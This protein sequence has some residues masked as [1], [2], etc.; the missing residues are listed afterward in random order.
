MVVIKTKQE[1]EIMREGGKVLAKIMKRLARE[2]RPGISTK[3]LEEMTEKLI[4]KINRKAHGLVVQPSFKG[5]RNF[6]ASL[7]VSINKE[8]VHGIPSESRILKNGDIVSLDLGLKYKRYYT[9]MAVTIPVGKISSEAKKLIKIT[10]KA[11][12]IGLKEIKPNKRIG[13][14]SSVIQRY[15]ESQGFSVNQKLTGHGIG[16]KVHEPPLIPNYAQG[17][18][19]NVKLVAGMTFCLE[20]MVNVGSSEVMCLFD[21][22]TMATADESLSAHFE[23]TVAVTERGCEVLTK[24]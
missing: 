18:D 7:C 10:K 9:D 4:D 8:L 19:E 24:Y 3:H 17:P 23:H 16:R 21:G 1:I 5:Y 14:I 22:W 11:L 15:V 12:E 2:V 6:P 13:D 20:P